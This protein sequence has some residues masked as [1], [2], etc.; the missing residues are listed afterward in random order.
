[1]KKCFLHWFA[2]LVTFLVT[3]W[4]YGQDITEQDVSFA[5]GYNAKSGY[6]EI[7]IPIYDDDGLDEGL[8]YGGNSS[9]KLR[10]P[11]HDPII[12]CRMY[13]FKGYGDPQGEAT[14]YWVQIKKENQSY[15][16]HLEATSRNGTVEIQNNYTRVECNR[17]GTMTKV[18]LRF[19]MDASVLQQTASY[20]VYLSIDKNNSDNDYEFTK[21]SPAISSLNIPYP[22]V[23]T[24][25]T[26][27]PGYFD[28]DVSV[29]QS[30]PGN[31][32]LSATGVAAEDT[33]SKT[34]SFEVG[35][36]A[37]KKTIT[38]TY[39]LPYT[40]VSKTKEVTIDQ[41]PRI[42]SFEA[43]DS[44]NGTTRLVWTVPKADSNGKIIDAG[45]F[46][47]ER[48]FMGSNNMWGEWETVASLSNDKRSYVD[49]E[50]QMK[51]LMTKYRISREKPWS[52]YRSMEC[53]LKK[54]LTHAQ[55]TE[56]TS[57]RLL[58]QREVELVWK[59]DYDK[60]NNNIVLTKDSKF[61]ITREVSVDGE[62]FMAE[63]TH[64]VA[65][66][67][68]M[69]S[70]EVCTYKT[71]IPQ[72]CVLY[73]WKIHLLPGDEGE[74]YKHK[75][76]LG[77]L[78]YLTPKKDDKGDL[79]IGED[80]KVEYD[81]NTKGI[82]DTEIA[83]LA[84]FTA[85]HGYFGDRV[86]LHWTLS[87]N[88]G[89]LDVFSVQ[90]R[91]YGG[92]DEEYVQIG[93]VEAVGG[94]VNYSFIDE[95][96]VP[97][98]LYEYMI[99]GTKECANEDVRTTD[100]TN[101]FAAAT[102]TVYGRITFQNEN[103][104]GVNDAE[105][106]LETT[107]DIYGK[108]YAFNNDYYL[109]VDNSTF[110][111]ST[112]NNLSLQMFVKFDEI[113]V[114]KA[115]LLHK[116]DM[117]E[118]YAQ[119]GKFFFKAGNDLLETNRSIE[120][121]GGTDKFIQLTAVLSEDSIYLYSENQ[122]LASK[123]H[124]LQT[125]TPSGKPFTMG[126]GLKGHLD[127]VRVW[128]KALSQTDIKKTY[129]RYLAG[130]EEGLIAYWNFNFAT[131]KEFYDFAHKGSKFYMNDG[132]IID[133]ENK[134][135][136]DAVLSGAEEDNP[137][138][139]QLSYKDYTDAD[140][141]YY[142]AGVPYVGN[143][144][145]YQILP[146]LGTHE[147]SPTKTQV[148]LSAGN[149]NHSA[150]FIDQSAFPV[151]GTIT[152]KGGTIPVEGVSFYVDGVVCTDSKKNIITSDAQGHFKIYVPVG[153]HEVKATKANHK[154][155]NDGRITDSYGNDIN[156]QDDRY[157]TVKITDITTVRYIGRVAG[158]SVE[159]AYPI[160]HSLSTNNLAEKLTVQLTYP[161]P[162]YKLHGSSDSIATMTHFLPS[163]WVAKGKKANTNEVKFRDNIVTISPN[164]E[165]GEF[166]V[167]LPPLDY[168][169]K[170][171]VPGYNNISG[172]NSQL[173]LKDAFALLNE[174]YNYVDSVE[175]KNEWVKTEYSDTVKYNSM[176]KFIARVKPTIQ[177]EQM[178]GTKVLPYLGDEKTS[179]LGLEGTKE[180]TLYDTESNTYTLGLPLFTQGNPY[181]L[182][183]SVFEEYVY[184]DESGNK[185][186]DHVSD[187]VPSQD[188][189][190]A[191]QTTMSS[192]ND[193]ET[194]K[195]DSA[196]VAYWTFTVSKI[197]LTSANANINVM[198]TVGND[199]NA[200]SFVWTSSFDEDNKVL[201]KG[202]VSKGNNFITSGPDKLLAVLRDPPGSNSYSYLEQ[203]TSF[204]VSSSYE[205]TITQ[206]GEEMMEINAGTELITFAGLGGGTIQSVIQNNSAEL[207]IEH[208]EEWTNSNTK[209]TT[210]TVNSTLTTSDTEDY[211][212]AMADLFIGYST[213][214]SY[215][216]ADVVALVDKDKYDANP[217]AYT[218][219]YPTSGDNKYVLVQATALETGT[220]FSTMFI[221]PQHYI[222][223]YLLPEM[224]DLRNSFLRQPTEMSP[225]RF[226]AEANATNKPIYVSKLL[227]D[228]ENYAKSNID[229]VFKNDALYYTKEGNSLFDGPSYKIYFPSEIPVK[230]DTID[231]LNQS[232]NKWI[233]RLADNE[234]AKVDAI[235]GNNL[236]KNFSIQAGS[237]V[238]YSEGFSN[239]RDTTDGFSF[240]V[241]GGAST[242]FGFKVLGK[243]F[244]LHVQESVIGA[245]GR[246]DETEEEASTT[247]GF[248]LADNGNDYL[249]VDVYRELGDNNNDEWFDDV[250]NKDLNLSTFIFRTRAGATSCP[251]EGEEVTKWYEPG[252]HV[253]S[254]ATMQIEVPEIAVENAF[255]ENVP[256]GESA[257]VT[258]YLR[259]N[260][261]IQE[262]G[263]FNLIVDDKSNPNGAGL[264]MDGGAI[265]NG[266]TI[267]VPAGE[268]LVKTLEVTKG[269]EMN[270][271]NLQ[272]VLASQCQGDP[273]ANFPAIAD[274]VSFSVHFTPSCSDVSLA[275]PS[276]NWTYNTEM[277][278]EII[279]QDTVHY[280]NVQITDFNVNYDNFKS[281]RLMYKP[282]SASDENWITLMNYFADEKYY[283]EAVENGMNAEMIKAEDKGT[284]NYKWYLDNMPDQP[285]DLCAV[286]VCNINNVDV[287][288]FSEVHSGIK[289]M[290]RPRLFGNP[291]PANGILTIEDEAKITFN[292]AIAAG[293]LTENNFEVTGI[294]NGTLTNHS[295]AVETDG[296]DE[297]VSELN[298]SFRA[299]DI[300]FEAWV[301]M[302]KDQNATF[303]EHT[304]DG[305]TLSF[306]ITSQR[307]LKTVVNGKEFV[308]EVITAK[309]FLDNWIHVAM[310]LDQ[311]EDA[312]SDGKL[313]LYCNYVPYLESPE[314]PAYTATAG[315]K[316]AKNLVGQIHNVR[317]WTT[318]RTSG[319]LQTQSNE[320]LSGNEQNLLSYYPMDEARGT[321][322]KDKARGLNLTMTGGT[323]ILPEGRS[324]VLNGSNSYLK[325]NSGSSVA[326]DLDNDYTI[327][328]WFKGD[329]SNSNSTLLASGKADGTDWGG[330]ENLFFLGFENGVLT[331]R[332][333][334]KVL[335]GNDNY[336]DDNW[337]HVAVA[338]NRMTDRAQMYVDGSL[339]TY[340]S[341][342][343]YGRI[344]SAYI[345]A[346]VTPVAI[347]SITNTYVNHFHGT[348]DDIRFW[349]LYKNEKSV[350]TGMSN[351][352]DGSEMGLLSYYPFEKH[353]IYNGI[354]EVQ[355]SLADDK[356]PASTG[357]SNSDAVAV[358][359]EM[360][361]PEIN[362][363]NR[364][365][366][367]DAFMTSAIAPVKDKGGVVDL[368]FDYV[369][370]DDALIITLKEDAAKI[371]KTT[372][373][374]TVSDVR[375]LNGNSIASPITWTAYIDR[376]QLKWGENELTLVKNV[377]EPL[378]FSV[379]AVNNGGYTKDYTISNYP[380]WMSVEPSSGTL[381]ATAKKEIK[382]TVD[383]SLNIGTYNEV[384]YLTNDEGVSEPLNITLKVNGNRPDW[385][386]NPADYK[387]S[388]NVYGAM[389]INGRYS[390]DLED[391]LAVFEDNVCVGVAN[392]EYI[393]V[394]DTYYA[395]LTVYS[396]VGSHKNLNFK[397]WDASTGT[398]YI[399]SPE[400]PIN[401]EADKIIGTSVDPVEFT[402]LDMVQLDI[403]LNDGWTWTSFNVSNESMAQMSDV[404]QYNQW[405]TGDEVKREDGGVATYGTE[406]GWQ[407]SLNSFDNTGMFL[408][409]SSYP[410]TLSV[411]GEPVD[412]AS[413]VLTINSVNSKGVAIWNYIP[414]LSQ[415]NLPLNE[416]LAG[417]EALE[418]DVIKSQSGFAMYNGN[419]GWIG[420]LTY[421]QPGYGYMLQ[422]KGTTSATLQ[423]P[424]SK[425]QGNKVA[426]ATRSAGSGTAM[427]DMGYA[428]TNYSRTMSMVATVDG[429][430]VE[431]GDVLKVYVDGELRGESPLIC[432]GESDEPLFFL[433]IA[434]EQKENVDMAVERNGEVIAAATSAATFQADKIE[435]SYSNPRVISFIEDNMMVYPS[436]FVNE[437]YI[438]KQVD[439]KADVKVTITDMKGAVV[440]LFENCNKQGKV[441][442]HWTG[443][444][445]CAPGVYIVNIVENGENHV[446]KVIKIKN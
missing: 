67:D 288:N 292:E 11:N 334:G 266:R 136:E 9:V 396:N 144:T 283:D 410:Q 10:L 232:I 131:S 127:D 394:N 239:V 356:V 155:L 366:V 189:V 118:L 278:T 28:V 242:D 309:D 229:E 346:G 350:K 59:W 126:K 363:A 15:L 132:K 38:A 21:K 184:Y 412:V 381:T 405:A 354:P 109:Q 315:Y 164:L 60:D 327:E 398:T 342:T 388:M 287:E 223:N 99:E 252:K 246:V 295:V 343:G 137:S 247:V 337:H 248:V 271:D 100:R 81:S 435:G 310:V 16:K 191:F 47:L 181:K 270:Y 116:E 256:S 311:N 66:A 391:V 86:E 336:L 13:S 147:F 218:A 373:T 329:G 429:V 18:T 122:L 101:G 6:F 344:A 82:N 133:F 258:L 290:Y 119:D 25:K 362:T 378:T 364:V 430:Q 420:S 153:T 112:K 78:E 98:T 57:A 194:V 318:A 115:S 314:V 89:S 225:E 281:I 154:F 428:N 253:L 111:D 302:P 30:Y 107:A 434:G 415:V 312:V 152:Y 34:F 321:V 69:D 260:S 26:G 385:S 108:S 324:L 442:I 384:I 146:R 55:V 289:D 40:T 178:Q 279:K 8:D 424:S 117:Y 114:A 159:E 339:V 53:E 169:V 203:G 210:T 437:L 440:A 200:T 276:K 183:A 284:I 308:S 426:P 211:V 65:C 221:Y 1:M 317:L 303:F 52:T 262:D 97:G 230:T 217:S 357:T 50:A 125:L 180:V 48:C 195:A 35:D 352:L 423:Y 27:S 207:H 187:H 74:Y 275:A 7:T 226:Q 351:R 120:E 209:T 186:N 274:T 422:R 322:L 372:V 23:S 84:S 432:K 72:S 157:S 331:Y 103:G 382:F 305:D 291:Q 250:F 296:K 323:W 341:A 31:L 87:E 332:N 389:K 365:T 427:L 313:I 202:S 33:D 439:E 4:A 411:I 193:I 241:G 371:E 236:L 92:L 22:I 285:Y 328:L 444:A 106:R 177:V 268:T 56:F 168:N 397:M 419:L 251:Y 390:N 277:P 214:L 413:H 172:N 335:S 43:K 20:E 404:L 198:A 196:G 46:I 418:G 355:F 282:S 374:F 234:K 149:V 233:A 421:M 75:S 406:T 319:Q 208:T 367:E 113:P 70:G 139:T 301:K 156:Y 29:N 222:E 445:S 71:V 261:A 220:Q 333:N 387:Y 51:P 238:E 61:I 190:V 379:E 417:Y 182:K 212:G 286:S 80:G 228:D 141:S 399:A 348:L 231:C 316:I 162:A 138:V 408:I 368:L 402:N 76:D 96:A 307:Q 171:S 243:G 240:I 44:T 91:E 409:R 204:T 441:D 320:L 338:V 121:L 294:K 254:E 90:R 151:S 235:A 300:T 347:N 395:L 205:Q 216:S 267:L 369:V 298:R 77:V 306:G 93:T 213:N 192:S 263:W 85:S 407:G 167:D 68:Y 130:D 265:G 142:I 219:V 143:G 163:S 39:K 105:V 237:T 170:V 135:V 326:L 165:T 383:E 129:D 37:Q 245:E 249:T 257:Y 64:E 272:L 88:S 280:M 359:G 436:P 41:Y 179:S 175:V 17:V 128:S 227:P 431:E 297:F 425:T 110:S 264:K 173:N 14:W 185:Q 150:N 392:N 386:V 433:S 360:E 134:Y 361:F 393:K 224:L 443:A 83:S 79:I 124:T 215:G 3:T 293:Y 199:E 345:Y 400:Y 377:D 95:R 259:N 104:Q 94:I 244:V 269:T 349:N 148:T 73:R 140:G 358:I 325:L 24:P 188:A 403:P 62:T 197:D 54:E 304:A 376:N 174:T 161:N 201:T 160:G 340:T 12:L 176:Q 416:A 2:L 446:Y 42:I 45:N 19:Y 102:G 206:S 401:F 166:I 255:I 330:S 353:T 5:S 299:K 380:S 32:F 58:T 145:L 438:K 370:N 158:G 414:Y 123:K 273:T 36:Q 375:D 63:E 49:E